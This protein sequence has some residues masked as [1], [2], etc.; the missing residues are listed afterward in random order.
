MVSLTL[1]WKI[2]SFKYAWKRK[3]KRRQLFLFPNNLHWS[4]SIFCLSSISSGF[5]RLSLF[6][7]LVSSSKMRPEPLRLERR[8]TLERSRELSFSGMT[9]NIL[10][11]CQQLLI[12]QTCQTDRTL[13]AN[14]AESSYCLVMARAVRNA[15]PGARRNQAPPSGT[16]RGPTVVPRA[17]CRLPMDGREK[18]GGVW[19]FPRLCCHGKGGREYERKDVSH[20][21]ALSLRFREWENFSSWYR[22][23]F[24]SWGQ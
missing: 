9:E 24:R 19:S 4:Q 18:G 8:V 13:E 14:C 17:F 15:A 6:H 5:F 11:N 2:F 16:A 23:R 7:S 3:A 12:K 10:M 21:M 1:S 20:A 22:S